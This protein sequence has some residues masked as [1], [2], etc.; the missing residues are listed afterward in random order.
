ME[1]LAHASTLIKPGHIRVIFGADPDCYP[2]QWVI[3]VSDADPVSTL[4][5]G[6]MQCQDTISMEK[7]MFLWSDTK[8]G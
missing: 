8:I 1:D 4:T 6:T 3:R 5:G 7:I 2:G